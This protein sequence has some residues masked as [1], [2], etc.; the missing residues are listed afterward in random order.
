[1]ASKVETVTRLQMELLAQSLSCTRLTWT[2]GHALSAMRS[3]GDRAHRCRW[4]SSV[5]CTVETG[6]LAR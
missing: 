3:N 2:L 1:M 6:A 4:R 5:G